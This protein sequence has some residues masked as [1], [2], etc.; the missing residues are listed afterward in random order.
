MA[1]SRSIARRSVQASAD[2]RTPLRWGA[3]DSVIYLGRTR[4]T[5][6][7]SVGLHTA[8]RILAIFGRGYNSAALLVSIYFGMW[9]SLLTLLFPSPK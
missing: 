5:K 1:G 3:G 7:A 8:R 4:P 6:T 2:Q 9:E